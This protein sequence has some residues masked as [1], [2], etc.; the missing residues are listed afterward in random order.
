MTKENWEELL[1]RFE[2][3]GLTQ[4]A[5]CAAHNLP[6]KQFVYRWNAHTRLRKAQRSSFEAISLLAKPLVVEEK[7]CILT[8]H[9]PNKIRYEVTISV[10]EV[11]DWIKELAHVNP[12]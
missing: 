12:F 11:K 10:K 4:K 8:I 1:N 5:F 6:L 2:L 7:P 3:S 9:L